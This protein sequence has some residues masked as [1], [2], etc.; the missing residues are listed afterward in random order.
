[1]I[2]GEDLFHLRNGHV[3]EV[4]VKTSLLRSIPMPSA[5]ASARVVP[6]LR[7]GVIQAEAHALFSAG[8]S[9]RLYHIFFIGGSV[10]DV[11]RV[12]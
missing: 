12:G 8:I 11:K 9:Q 6:I 1:M 4:V 2:G 7:L 3:I 5:G 10:D